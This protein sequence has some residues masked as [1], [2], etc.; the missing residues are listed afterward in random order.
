MCVSYQ[1]VSVFCYVSMCIF[2]CVCVCANRP[3]LQ[4]V[5]M[6]CVAAQ[7]SLLFMLAQRSL[8][9]CVLRIC[10]RKSVQCTMGIYACMHVRTFRSRRA[11]SNIHS[12][13]VTW[14]RPKIKKNMETYFAYCRVCFAHLFTQTQTIRFVRRNAA[15]RLESHRS[16]HFPK[17]SCHY[18]ATC[19]QCI[20][21]AISGK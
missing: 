21:P 20:Q 4:Y 9:S 7:L 15:C 6:T 14:C 12:W 3:R 16:Y 1:Y 13:T 17:I 18:A 5:R 8:Y 19:E 2:V 10:M 11:H